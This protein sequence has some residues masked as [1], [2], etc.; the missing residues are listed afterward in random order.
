[1]TKNVIGFVLVDAPHS[2]LNNSGSD[3][4]DRTDNLVKVKTIRSG[5]D[6]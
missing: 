1:M 3:A 5:R 4:G 2:A 6:I